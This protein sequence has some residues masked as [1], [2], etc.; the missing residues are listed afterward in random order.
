MAETEML[1]VFSAAN[2]DG[3]DEKLK[4]VIDDLPENYFRDAVAQG[5]MLANEIHYD[6]KPL[7]VIFWQM[8]CERT[9][10]HVCAS[11]AMTD[12]GDEN[13]WG[14]G[15]EMLALKHGLRA[16]TFQTNRRGHVEKGLAWGATIKGLVMEKVL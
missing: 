7:Y 11:L 13:A 1:E 16:V 4:L 15:V 2:V 9:K 5:W 3:C 10:M 8:T 14:S 6:G 12:R